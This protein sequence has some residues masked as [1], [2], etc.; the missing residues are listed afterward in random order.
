L[1]IH[2]GDGTLRHMKVVALIIG[3]V[4]AVVAAFVFIPVVQGVIV[5]MP[6]TLSEMVRESE[7]KQPVEGEVHRDLVYLESWAGRR[8][9][10]LYEPL[11][12]FEYG[13][14]PLVVFLHGGSWIH[15]DK[16]TIRVIDRFLRR[17][18]EAGYFVA[19][20]NY[21]TN[22]LRGINGPVE[23]TKAAIRLLAAEADHFGYD[24]QNIGLYGV[25]AGGHL[26]LLAGSTM[27]SDIF[28]FAFIF[29]ESA[30]TDLM[31]MKEG[32]AFGHS[33]SFRLFPNDRLRELSPITYA[34]AGLPP[35]LLFHGG[36][37]RTVHVRQ[38]TRYA[39]AIKEVGGSV[40]LVLYPE[41]NHAFLNLSDDDWYEQETRALAYFEKQ[42]SRQAAANS[43][44]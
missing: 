35:V 3:V 33:V 20:V 40:E 37:D 41:G 6:G 22:V 32:D 21:T 13:R 4:C 2:T 26:G 8:R 43:F 30:P 34:D 17:M 5:P 42:F 14:P 7:A 16:I 36:A 1:T 28:S 31:A 27:E 10:D 19:A 12:E 15:G 44:K 23:N 29:A 39:E 38:S 24:P 18:R 11:G 25:S 9:F